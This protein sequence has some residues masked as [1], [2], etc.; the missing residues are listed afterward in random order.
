MVEWSEDR[1]HCRPRS[2]QCTRQLGLYGSNRIECYNPISSDAQVCLWPMGIVRVPTY[3]RQWWDFCSFAFLASA[4]FNQPKLLCFHGDLT[5]TRVTLRTVMSL[6]WRPMC[7]GVSWCV[8]RAK[9]LET[10]GRFA[11]WPNR[12]LTFFTFTQYKK[13]V[14]V[15]RSLNVSGS[16]DSIHNLCGTRKILGKLKCRLIN[17][18]P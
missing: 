4:L 5:I 14:H 13:L 15:S 17:E 16:A 6:V 10:I 9:K 3:G 2:C 8:E 7:P 18:F 12:Q 1:L 11:R